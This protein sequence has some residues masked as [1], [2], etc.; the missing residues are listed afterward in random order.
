VW[1]GDGATIPVTRPDHC[2]LYYW[3][4]WAQLYWSRGSAL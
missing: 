1:E 2:S 4:Y 3:Y